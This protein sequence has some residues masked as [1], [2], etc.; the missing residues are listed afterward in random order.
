MNSPI[1]RNSPIPYYAQVKDVVRQWIQDKRWK[2]GE[3]IPGEHEMCESFDVSRP[4]IRQALNELV[5]EG[6]IRRQKGK[7]TFVTEPKIKEGLVQR[8]T[9]FHHDMTAQGYQPVNRVL[10]Q[11]VI[12]TSEKLAHLLHLQ[13]HEPVLEIERLRFIHDEPIVLV[14]TYL[15]QRICPDLLTADLTHQSL[16]ALLEQKCGVFIASGHRT[17]EAVAADKYSAGL[18]QVRKGTPLIQLDSVSYS[19]SGDPI[20][21]YRAY[22]RGDRSA[23]EIELVRV[24]EGEKVGEALTSDLPP[25]MTVKLPRRTDSASE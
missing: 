7:G 8:L 25:P 24:V 13:P 18:L 6:L 12:P 1:N 15:P 17:V 23:F 5:A 4:V 11:Q 2:S 14:T 16:Y 22:H 20:E 10:K 3:Q 21:Y 19:S 9:G